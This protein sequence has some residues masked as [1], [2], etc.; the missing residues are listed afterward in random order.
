MSLVRLTNVE[1]ANNDAKPSG[2]C[3]QHHLSH[4]HF[5]SLQVVCPLL[6]SCLSLLVSM[7]ASR[8]DL[9]TH[10]RWLKFVS[11]VSQASLVKHSSSPMFHPSSL[12]HPFGH[13]GLHL[14]T[15]TVNLTTCSDTSA[16]RS[17]VIVPGKRNYART[18]VVWLC[19]LHEPPHRL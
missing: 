7:R 14:S 13:I 5:F 19:A 16:I 8:T 2:Y 12:L 10:T 18:F 6:H 1:V 4:A 3:A 15:G 11:V 17:H 9:T